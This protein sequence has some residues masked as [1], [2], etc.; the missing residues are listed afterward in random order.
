MYLHCVLPQIETGFYNDVKLD[1]IPDGLDSYYNDHWERIKGKDEKAWFEYKLPIISMITLSKMS[2]SVEMIR[3]YAK[4]PKTAM[5]ISVL[6]E[7]KQFFFEKNVGPEFLNIKL[8]KLY[9]STFKE[10]L[11]KKSQIQA[12]QI[13]IKR[14]VK[15]FIIKYQK[16]YSNESQLEDFMELH[17]KL[18]GEIRTG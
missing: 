16:V 15:D 8:Y 7:W 18:K 4:L 5:V 10:F 1:E 17:K 14:F 6:E 13:D 2:L 11:K 9:H 3:E 12:E